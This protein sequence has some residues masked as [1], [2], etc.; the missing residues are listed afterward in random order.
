MKRI[1][2]ILFALLFGLNSQAQF[3]I[4]PYAYASTQLLLDDVPSAYAAHSVSRKL[5]TAYSGNCL[6]V[7]RSSDN[8]TQDIGF[9]NNILDTAALMAFT[10]TSSAFVRTLYDQSGNG[11]DVQQ[12]TNGNQPQIVSSGTLITVNS[13]PAMQHA[14]VSQQ[15]LTLASV[16]TNYNNLTTFSVCKATNTSANTAY[17]MGGNPTRWFLPRVASSVFYFG[18][19]GNASAINLGAYNTNLN[20]FAAIANGS[21]VDG[22]TNGAYVGSIA[23]SSA[24]T[25]VIDIGRAATTYFEGFTQEFITWASDKDAE[26]T[27]IFNNIN[28][29][30]TIY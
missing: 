27:T 9:V 17:T 12:T 25:T 2:I 18:Y 8:T 23:E 4:N 16:T 30:Y 21:N 19:A 5:R 29:F 24:N 26:K 15:F 6:E 1:F 10:G 14:T 3:L 28:N 22:Y 7:R 11:R 20:V 13:K